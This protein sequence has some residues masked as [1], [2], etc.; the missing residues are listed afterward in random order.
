MTARSNNLGIG[1]N[2]SQIASLS[3]TVIF[4]ADGE[5]LSMV[6]S[7]GEAIWFCQEAWTGGSSHG[8]GLHESR[9]WRDEDGLLIASTMQDGMVRLRREDG[10]GKVGFSPNAM[11][12][13]L[14]ASQVGKKAR[15]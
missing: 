9:M 8:R 15:L 7:K 13:D 14:E 6:D 11:I 10:K 2:F 12:K 1:D 4:H 5:E 3:H